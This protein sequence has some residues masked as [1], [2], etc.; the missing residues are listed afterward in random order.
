MYIMNP[1]AFYHINMNNFCLRHILKI[2]NF[3][4]QKHFW[5]RCAQKGYIKKFIGSSPFAFLIMNVKI[6]SNFQKECCTFGRKKR[7]LKKIRIVH[8]QGLNALNM[9]KH[10]LFVS[11]FEHVNFVINR[12]YSKNNYENPNYYV[13][14]A[15]FETY[16]KV[17]LRSVHSLGWF[18]W[19]CF[20]PRNTKNYLQL[21]SMLF[22]NMQH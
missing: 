1:C 6:L 19:L 7:C 8:F 4:G 3:Q 10:F 13:S 15:I 9:Q 2:D 20:Y 17:V 21:L 12:K 11:N 14:F 18:L 16:K 22:S 5:T